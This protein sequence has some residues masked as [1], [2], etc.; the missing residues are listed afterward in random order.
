MGCANSKDAAHAPGGSGPGGGG[1]GGGGGPGKAPLELALPVPPG[2]ACRAGAHGD[3]GSIGSVDRNSTNRGD[4]DSGT[5]P[6]SLSPANASSRFRTA[7]SFD[8]N[9][10]LPTSL[11]LSDLALITEFYKLPDTLGHVLAT[12]EKEGFIITDD[13]LLDCNNLVRYTK[14]NYIICTPYIIIPNIFI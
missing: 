10:I 7:T 11:V 5:R 12:A 2:D 1:A 13:V 9:A 4:R 14:L 3:R 8:M 6:P